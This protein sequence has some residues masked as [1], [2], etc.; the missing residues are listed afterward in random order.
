MCFTSQTRVFFISAVEL[1][2]TIDVIVHV[3]SHESFWLLQLLFV[4]KAW[5]QLNLLKFVISKQYTHTHNYLENI[6]IKPSQRLFKHRNAVTR[7]TW[8]CL[9]LPTSSNYIFGITNWKSPTQ[10]RRFIL[11][12]DRQTVRIF[13]QIS[14]LETLC[15]HFHF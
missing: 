12:Q 3:N 7:C 14:K 11:Q 9:H 15:S 4:F 10:R 1:Y 13:V 8:N 5:L 2:K 6:A